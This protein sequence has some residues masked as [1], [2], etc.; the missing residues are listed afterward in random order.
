MSDKR[1][2]YVFRPKADIQSNVRSEAASALGKLWS[3]AYTLMSVARTS[4][5]LN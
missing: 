5:G 3:L 4:P 2:S 1:V